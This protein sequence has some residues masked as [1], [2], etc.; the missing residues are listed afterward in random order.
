MQKTLKTPLKKKKLLQLINEFSKVTEYEI[1]RHKFVAFLYTN[2]EVAEREIIKKTVPFTI[3]PKIIKY[4]GINLT[5]E[6]KNL[7]SEDYKTLMR[8]IENDTSKWKDI[9][10]SWI[11]RTNIKMFILPKAIYRCNAIPIKIPTAFFMEL[12]QIILKFV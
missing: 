2:N 8:E 6:V 7:Y 5:K 4:L 12:E 9:P 11:G 3:A 1:N 10:C